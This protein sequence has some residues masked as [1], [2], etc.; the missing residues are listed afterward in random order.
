MSEKQETEMTFYLSKSDMDGWYLYSVEDCSFGK[1]ILWT[2]KIENTILFSSE[3][4]V[5][6]FKEKVLNHVPVNIHRV[7]KGK[8][9]FVDF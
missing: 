6:T 8:F 5:E 3:E 4:R 1:K 9:A 2:R 7:L